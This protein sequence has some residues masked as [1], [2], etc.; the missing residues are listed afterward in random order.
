M[1]LYDVTYG[2]PKLVTPG[3]CQGN[4]ILIKLT[5]TAHPATFTKMVNTIDVA[6]GNLKPSAMSRLI[7]TK[8]GALVGH[9][10]SEPTKD[11]NHLW[12]SMD[13]IFLGGRDYSALKQSEKEDLGELC[14]KA[15]GSLLRWRISMLQDKWLLYKQETDRVNRHGKDI[16]VSEY[17]INNDFDPKP[18]AATI[19]DLVKKW[20][21][22]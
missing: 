8:C 6:L 13:K 4:P 15:M 19:D 5:K 10:S 16:Y 2:T 20:G 17:W 11:I 21:K 7:W 22:K 12:N 9:H 18:K 14:L 1:P 3:Q